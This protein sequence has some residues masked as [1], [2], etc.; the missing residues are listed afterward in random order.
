MC[1]LIDLLLAYFFS[2]QLA[3][4]PSSKSLKHETHFLPPSHDKQNAI[5]N[6]C[7]GGVKTHKKMHKLF[8]RR[9]NNPTHGERFARFSTSR[10]IMMLFHQDIVA[11]KRDFHECKSRRTYLYSY[12]PQQFGCARK[13]KKA[14]VSIIPHTRTG[15][16]KVERGTRRDRTE[17]QT[18]SE[19]K[20]DVCVMFY[21]WK[22]NDETTTVK[23]MRFATLFDLGS[24]A[25]KQNSC[26]E[27]L[28]QNE[29]VSHPGGETWRKNCQ[30]WA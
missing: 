22:W 17:N 25:N 5:N 24:A 21:E 23:W 11:L 13:E 14:A 10:F 6:S 4:I 27:R 1:F 15:R 20:M 8:D 26:G 19:P 12:Q 9:P 2:V 28:A 7:G 18:R 3:N 29:R 30:K 16:R